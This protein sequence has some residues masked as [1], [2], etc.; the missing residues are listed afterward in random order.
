MSVCERSSRALAHL[1]VQWYLI[2]NLLF[3]ISRFV[4]IFFWFFHHRRFLYYL[5]VI[6]EW[7]FRFPAICGEFVCLKHMFVLREMLWK[8]CLSIVL[9]ALHT[10]HIS[11]FSSKQMKFIIN[12]CTSLAALQILASLSLFLSLHFHNLYIDMHDAIA[13]YSDIQT[14]FMSFGLWANLFLILFY[15]KK[16]R[17][18]DRFQSHICPYPHRFRNQTTKLFAF[19]IFVKIDFKRVTTINSRIDIEVNTEF[20]SR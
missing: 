1:P 17:K 6:L 4:F 9:C 20:D 7:H 13:L 15:L 10:T 3:W 18:F 5:R 2:Y 19:E 12:S 8:M 11:L 16:N 14:F